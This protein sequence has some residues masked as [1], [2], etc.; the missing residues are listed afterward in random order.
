MRNFF[1][2]VSS[3]AKAAVSKVQ[4]VAKRA[5]T[6]VKAAFKTRFGRVIAK[7]A[8]IA[9]FL[10]AAVT[11]VAFAMAAPLQTLAFVVG[12]VLTFVLG[13]LALVYCSAGLAR[14][15]GDRVADAFDAVVSTARTVVVFFA[16]VAWVLFQVAVTVAM[17]A[18]A[19][20]TPWGVVDLALVGWLLWAI[21]TESDALT[22]SQAAAARKSAQTAD[23]ALSVSRLM[24]DVRRGASAAT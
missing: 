3:V 4:A 18:C 23:L 19:F 1:S 16:K 10:V 6:A 11:G 21:E 12:A 15:F 20:A 14:L 7:F 8:R 9:S 22:P 5:A 2:R 24:R 13:R 17:V